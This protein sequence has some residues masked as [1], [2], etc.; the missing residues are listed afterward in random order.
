MEKNQNISRIFLWFIDFYKKINLK[1]K[2]IENHIL[3]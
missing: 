2:I 3:N 1:K